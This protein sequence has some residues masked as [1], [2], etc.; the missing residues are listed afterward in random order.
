MNENPTSRALLSIIR[1]AAEPMGVSD[2]RQ[3]NNPMVAVNAAFES[4]TGYPAAATL[5][6]N[7]RFLQGPATDRAATLRIRG[8]IEARRGC[9]EWLVNYRQDGSRFWNL[10]FMVPVF[11][12]DGTL[13]HFFANQ[14]D[15]SAEVPQGLP[16]YVLGRSDLPPEGEADFQALLREALEHPGLEAAAAVQAGIAAAIRLNEITTRLERDRGI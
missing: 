10:L 15:M 6:R 7:C 1:H 14:R 12:P 5:G 16:D 2:P 3:P 4:L 8:C 11:A 9:V 13:L